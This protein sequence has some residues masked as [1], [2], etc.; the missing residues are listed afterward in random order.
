MKKLFTFIAIAALAVACCNKQPAALSV[1]KFFENPVALVGQ[2]TTVIGVVQTICCPA[3]GQFCIGTD[4]QKL[5]VIPPAD[6][7][8]CKK[9]IGKELTI[10]G[11][12]NEYIVNEETLAEFEEQA[13]AVECAEMKAGML[14]YAAELR[15]TFGAKGEYSIYYIVA[16]EM[17]CDK[18]ACKEKKESCGE[19]KE[20]CGEKKEGCAEKKEGCCKD[21]EG[22]EGCGEKKEGCCKDKEGEKKEGCDKPCDKKKVE[23]CGEKK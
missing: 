13:N 23:D 11:V 18:D 21:K 15:E 6:K 2:E 22:K 3:T 19:K 4:E 20:S 5:K 7:K 14:Q 10:K 16:S 8:I 17:A 12:V 1:E 9:I